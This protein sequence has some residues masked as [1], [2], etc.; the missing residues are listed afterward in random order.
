[1]MTVA[2]A[3]AAFF[4]FVRIQGELQAGSE[5]HS[6][7]LA[8]TISSKIDV[9]V[10]D[11]DTSAGDLNVYLKNTGGSSVPTTTGAT[12]PTT[13]FILM[14]GTQNVVCQTYL[15]SALADCT[16]GCSS[17]ITVGE[18]QK[19]T[20]DLTSTCSVASYSNDSSFS[21]ELDFSGRAATGGVFT[22]G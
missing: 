9:I 13:N 5:S 17:D 22:I 8:E 12:A 11:Y 2:A 6:G 19:I 4:W 3:G 21:F 18:T 7:N 15:G 14:D 20:L 16:T 1:M 10:A